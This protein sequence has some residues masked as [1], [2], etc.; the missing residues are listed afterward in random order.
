M[1]TPPGA[2][3]R[4]RGR[5]PRAVRAARWILFGLLLASAAIT[6]FGLPEL[7][8]AV[9]E[10]RWPPAALAVPAALLG[11]FA[12][13]YAAYRIALVRA[14]R[15]PAGRAL[16]RIAV[17]GAVVGAVAGLVLV[18]PDAASPG[19]GPVRLARPLAS[20]NPE[21]RALAAE[22]V[23]SRPREEALAAVDR[24]VDLLGDR[25]PEVRRQARLSLAAL[26]GRDVGGEGPDAAARWREYWQAARAAPPAGR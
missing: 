25:S 3:D 18:P 7:Q 9:S 14:G 11:L 16:V 15:Y 5:T 23:R 1:P 8:R 26:A 10:G 20:E 12:I 17:M 19:E 22:V 2:P 13:G 21:V 6:L 4:P 24:L